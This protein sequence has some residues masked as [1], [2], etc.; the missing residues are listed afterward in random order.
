MK[1]GDDLSE[2]CGN[3]EAICDPISL[4][5]AKGGAIFFA[6]DRLLGPIFVL[7]KAAPARAALCFLGIR[8]AHSRDLRGVDDVGNRRGRQRR[9]LV[10]A[11]AA[12]AALRSLAA[13][14]AARISD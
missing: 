5:N 12:H 2:R 4:P 1:F 8:G 9:R 6:V 7:A 11:E 13:A 3:T 14:T 10:V